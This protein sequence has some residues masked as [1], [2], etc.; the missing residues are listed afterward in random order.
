MSLVGADEYGEDV[1]RGVDDDAAIVGD[2]VWFVVLLL[3]FG[4]EVNCV[5]CCI[6]FDY[7]GDDYVGI[8]GKLVVDGERLGVVGVELLYWT[9]DG[10]EG[11]FGV[12]CECG[13]F[14]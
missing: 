6:F 1:E 14:G 13:E 12:F 8:D 2:G 11:G 7:R 5:W 9:I 3:R 4:G 10:F